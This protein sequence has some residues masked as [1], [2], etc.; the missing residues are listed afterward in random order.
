VSRSQARAYLGNISI[1]SFDRLENE[2][3][4]FP[5]GLP[6]LPGSRR[7]F[8]VF[9]ELE[10][11]RAAKRDEAYESQAR[12]RRRRALAQLEEESRANRRRQRRN[13]VPELI[14]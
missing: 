13:A 3:P 8:Y 1:P 5:R 7:K 6:L 4:A 14:G 2:D 9:E 12:E 10:A 11:W